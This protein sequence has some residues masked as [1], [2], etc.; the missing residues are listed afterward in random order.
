MKDEC[1]DTVARWRLW[2]CV[3]A[4]VLIALSP[5][6]AA[7]QTPNAE[8]LKRLSLEELLRIEITTVMRVPEPTSAIPAAVYV[9]TQD[10]IRRSGATSFPEVL[11]L[12]PG[13]QVAR[14]DAARYA[15][16]IR[17]FADR[18]ARS[19]LV[20]IDG[21]AV[22]SP[23]FAGTYW[24]V[25][26]TLLEDVERIEIIRGPGGTLW[27]ANAVN[28]IINIITKRSQDTQGTLVT[29]TFGSDAR[30]PIGVRFGGRAGS[31]GYFRAYAKAFDR[32][33]QFHPDG[34]DYDDSSM[35]QG[36]FRSDWTLTRSRTLT[37]Q[38]D[39]YAGELG[40]RFSVPLNTRRSHRRRFVTLG[41][42]AETSWRGGWRQ[43]SAASTNCRP[44][45][46]GPA[47]MNARLPR[48]ETRS[49]LIS[50]IGVDSVNG[51]ASCGAP[52]ID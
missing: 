10:D 40:Q 15:I 1:A 17:G 33:P 48:L 45:T 28:G 21:R 14:Q 35:V 39:M 49:I 37:V 6:A 34:I 12:A 2:V 41:F 8:D 46:I 20:L 47:V 43:R 50:N 44:T 22:Y 18:L 51:T 23:L 42:L 31:K 29:A 7:A 52:A 5:F 19:M 11:R 32:D 25:Q 38:G 4:V 3:G 16:G 36:G 13:L 27:G 9:I 30:G 26:D 24:E